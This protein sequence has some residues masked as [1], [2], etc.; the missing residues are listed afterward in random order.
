[1]TSAQ[2]A[3]NHDQRISRLE[4]LMVSFGDLTTEISKL[5]QRNS[6]DIERLED[7]MGRL[8][9][10]MGRLENNMGRLENNMNALVQQMSALT[11]RVDS[12]AAAGERQD[13]I[14]DYLLRREAGDIDID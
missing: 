1:M 2:P 11:R 13:R 3:D 4:A 6:S 9:N 12:L 5:A 7:N 8:E 14:L 10:N